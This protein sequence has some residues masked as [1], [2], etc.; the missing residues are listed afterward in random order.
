MK[1][2]NNKIRMQSIGEDKKAYSPSDEKT[3]KL[4]DLFNELIGRFDYKK[5]N[6]HHQ[7]TRTPHV[8]SDVLGKSDVKAT[9]YDIYKTVIYH[10]AVISQTATN[11]EHKESYVMTRAIR[12]ADGVEV[13]RQF[14][15]APS[16]SNLAQ[17][18]RPD[19]KK[20]EAERAKIVKDTEDLATKKHALFAIRAQEEERLDKAVAFLRA[21]SIPFDT[22]A[23]IDELERTCKAILHIEANQE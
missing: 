21:R 10:Y 3:E 19:L 1:K 17:V 2:N 20:I 5:F 22:R 18:P 14:E 6:Y 11:T 9:Y 13:S 16:I 8:K 7:E 15:F 23:T 12:K 4:T